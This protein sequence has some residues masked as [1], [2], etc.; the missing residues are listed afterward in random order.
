MALKR[1]VAGLGCVCVCVC[2]CVG[3]VGGQK[4]A[5]LGWSKPSVTFPGHENWIHG[6]HHQGGNRT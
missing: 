4:W 6:M 2:V 3:G 1:D 5:G